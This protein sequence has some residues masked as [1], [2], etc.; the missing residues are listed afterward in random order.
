MTTVYTLSYAGPDPY[1]LG[2]YSTARYAYQALLYKYADEPWKI[3]SI[4]PSHDDDRIELMNMETGEVAI[5]YIDEMELDEC[6][7]P[8]RYHTEE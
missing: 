2:V 3:V 6:L 7:P 8:N 5:W 4:G 1:V